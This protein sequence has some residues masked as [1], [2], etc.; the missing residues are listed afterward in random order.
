MERTNTLKLNDRNQRVSNHEK[1]LIMAGAG[2]GRTAIS[3]WK[4]MDGRR[5]K[6]ALGGSLPRAD[7]ETGA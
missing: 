6:S 7:A 5:W 1:W 2:W 4:E 3:G